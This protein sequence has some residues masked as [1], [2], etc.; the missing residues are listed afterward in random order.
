MEPCKNCNGEGIVGNGDQ[1]WLKQGHL[2]TCEVCAGTGK[3]SSG[4]AVEQTPEE[5]QA[6]EA[7]D[8]QSQD[9]E[10]KKSDESVA[11]GESVGAQ[12][13][14]TEVSTAEGNGEGQADTAEGQGESTSTTQ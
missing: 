2:H 5:K 12:N 10:E 9:G 7:T 3:V 11:E 4:Q 13:D 6:T 1:P 8:T 14:S